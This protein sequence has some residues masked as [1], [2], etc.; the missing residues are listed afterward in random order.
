M[1]DACR[2]S[3]K[4]SD[5][6]TVDNMK[7]RQVP[8]ERVYDTELMRISSNWF[9]PF[10]WVVTGQWHMHNESNKHTFSDITLTYKGVATLVFVLLATG[11]NMDI[12]S[13]INQVPKIQSATEAW[14]IHFTCEDSFAPI[15]PSLD[16]LSKGVNVLHFVHN[17]DWTKVVV[18]GYWKDHNGCTQTVENDVVVS[19]C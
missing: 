14:T 5:V 15:E 13:H 6:I 16:L 2:T 12:D 4:L 17:L 1:A 8:R 10:E 7:K 9:T 11:T 19:V 18:H 3:F